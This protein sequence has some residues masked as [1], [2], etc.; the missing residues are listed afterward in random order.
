ME[1]PDLGRINPS[2]IFELLNKTR[3]LSGAVEQS[4]IE[5]HRKESENARLEAENEILKAEKTEDNKKI[6]TDKLTELDNRRAIDEKL[7]TLVDMANSNGE[8]LAVIVTDIDF[9]KWINDGFG[10][11][12]GD[13][14]IKAV[15]EAAKKFEGN[16]D[17]VGRLGGDEFCIV[18]PG[19]KPREGHS[20]AELKSET[21]ELVSASLNEAIAKLN[22]PFEGV[23]VSVGIAVLDPSDQISPETASHLLAQADLDC[24]A[25]KAER[26]A[27]LRERGV[28]FPVDDRGP[29]N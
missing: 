26:K 28:V 12:A 2:R 13:E 21:Y 11:R 24:K 23:G 18:Q 16:P 20:L 29:N 5:L 15:A 7:E 22:L 14:V 25:D 27:V 17:L 4:L 8:P 10:F 6:Y 19:F 3:M 1:S 9:F